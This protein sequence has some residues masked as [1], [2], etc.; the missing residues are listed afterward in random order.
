MEHSEIGYEGG[1][2]REFAHDRDQLSAIVLAVLKLRVL[3]SE[4]YFS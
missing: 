4:G 3:L 1:K 2:R